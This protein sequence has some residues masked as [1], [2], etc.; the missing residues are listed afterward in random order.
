VAAPLLFTYFKTKDELVH[1]LYRE[2]DAVAQRIYKDIPQPFIAAALR[3]LREMT[4]E[5]MRQEPEKAELYR[6]AGFGMLW[7]GIT[8]R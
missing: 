3:A 1:A 2:M 6:I 7:T 8:C 4:M 5:L